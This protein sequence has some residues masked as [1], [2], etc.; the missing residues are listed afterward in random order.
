M[1]VLTVIA[2]LA[3]RSRS[4]RAR[5]LSEGL[6]LLA[7]S[8]GFA[9]WGG[10]PLPSSSAMSQRGDVYWLRA[11]AVVWWLLGARFVASLMV[12]V[13]GRDEPVRQA[14]LFS[15]LVAGAIYLTA[16]LVVLSSVL[17]L[18]LKGLLATSGVIAIVLGLA[19]QNTLSDVFSGIA[20]GIDQPFRI[21]D[22][23]SIAA[24]A[25]G[26]VVQMN[27]RCIRLQTDAEDIALI[28]N[29][30]VARSQILNHSAPTPR[31]ADTVDIP[32]ASTARSEA[33]SELIRQAALL[34]PSLLT[35]PAPSVTVKRL[36]LS[37]TTFKI[38]YCVAGS[39]ELSAARS[40]ILRQV[41]R[42]FRY[43]GVG[44]EQVPESARLLSEI[45]MFEMLSAAQIAQ[46][47]SQ[48]ETHRIEPGRKLFQQGTVGGSVFIVRSGIL[49]MLREDDGATRSCGKIGPGEYL[50]EISMMT[51]KPHP[52]SAIAVTQ[53]D[54]LELPRSAL[55]GLTSQDDGLAEALE[56]S[57]ERGLALLDRDEGART[58]VQF[59]DARSLL[60]QV[61][62]FIRRFAS[63]APS[64]K[65]DTT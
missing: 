45:A 25:E 26:V 43:G 34:C 24:S 48:L 7:L 11:L 8:G 28:P 33:L 65:F 3:I 27:W 38:S 6:L 31:R 4:P 30:V 10:S 23:V 15:D 50:G 55:D 44:S 20:V 39:S 14:R 13:L 22:R 5:L 37:S 12:M 46:L 18:Q 53:S 9:L 58:V 40:Q 16:A 2:L 36:G 56:R 17:G 32:V 61:Q 49:E 57:A 35:T 51:G 21:G 64:G 52:V 63:S 41:R 47:D 29:S 59:D 54:V 60:D 1:L 19:S 42:L 62:G